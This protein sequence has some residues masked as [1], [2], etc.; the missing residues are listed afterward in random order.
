MDTIEIVF[1]IATLIVGPYIVW[2][3]I[4]DRKNP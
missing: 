4:Q 1:I 2:D 3:A